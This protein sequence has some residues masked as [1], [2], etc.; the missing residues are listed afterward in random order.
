MTANHKTLSLQLPALDR[1]GI[2]L[3]Q[4]LGGAVNLTITG[5]LATAGVANLVVPQRVGVYAAGDNSGRT[6]TITGTARNGQSQSEAITGPTAGASVYTQK[7]F[8]TVTQ[9]AISGA[10]TGDV[11]VGT[12][13][14]GSTAPLVA[15]RFIDPANYGYGLDVGGDAVANIEVAYEDL[16]P[17]WDL[18][19]NNPSWKQINPQPNGVIQGP[20]SM[21]RLTN[22][23][24]TGLSTLQILTPLAGR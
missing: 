7:D 1:N 8:L 14:V 16:A 19:E 4:T 10:S 23:S 11:E 17:Q 9:V 22:V 20:V 13:G 18:T 3:A 6:F 12:V 5:A 21:I 15:D 2:S 24:G